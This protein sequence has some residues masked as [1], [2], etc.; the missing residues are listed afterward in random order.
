MRKNYDTICIT[1]VTDDVVEGRKKLFPAIHF[2]F[3]I[4]TKNNKLFLNEKKTL[5]YIN[6]KL[7]EIEFDIS[8]IKF[9]KKNENDYVYFN[10]GNIDELKNYIGNIDEIRISYGF[11]R[12][13]FTKDRI[14]KDKKYNFVQHNCNDFSSIILKR[15]DLRDIKMMGCSF[16]IKRHFYQIIKFNKNRSAE[17]IQNAESVNLFDFLNMDSLKTYFRPDKIKRIFG[18]SE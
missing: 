16:E 6:H 11:K 13:T 5:F 12:V 18:Q 9:D 10:L 7:R 3:I 4:S 1:I 14:F 8:Y 17:L 2:D 15:N